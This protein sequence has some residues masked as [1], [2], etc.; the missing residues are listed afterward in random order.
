MP[1]ERYQNLCKKDIVASSRPAIATV[2]A[3]ELDT[4]KPKFYVLD[5]F[6]YPRCAY[7]FNQTNPSD[8]RAFDKIKQPGACSQS[9]QM[10]K[11][12]W[13]REFDTTIGVQ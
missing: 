2:A 3:D 1:A 7:S 5:M 8:N 9:C 6:P 13:C 11:P 10:R 12:S 4:S